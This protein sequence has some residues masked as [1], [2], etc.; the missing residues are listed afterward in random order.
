[1]DKPSALHGRKHLSRL[2][3][4]APPFVGRSQE[5]E[6]LEGRLQ[7]AAAG[8]P[9]VILI[10]GQAGIGKTRLLQ[11]LRSGAL[12][13]GLQVGYGRGYEDL[14]L[15]YLPVIDV[16]HTLFD[17]VPQGLE[18]LVDNDAEVLR[19]LMPRD[20]ALAHVTNPFTSTQSDQDRAVRIVAGKFSSEK[21]EP[22]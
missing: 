20:Q 9:H 4:T 2:A 11:E 13:R 7:E 15:P 16:L 12:R 17:R 18:H 8:R 6:W 1:M 14:A 10:P 22:P 19:W 21:E 3:G 5:L